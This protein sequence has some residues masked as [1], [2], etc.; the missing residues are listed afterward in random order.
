MAI[1]VKN[2]N[3]AFQRLL[4]DVVKDYRDFA[5]PF[6][7]DIIMSSGGASC[8]RAVQNHVK[9]LWVVL[10]RPREKK[11]AVSADKANMFVESWN[12]PLAADEK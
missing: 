3:A 8:E 10:Q 7:N 1:G 5:R 9:H 11:L 6:V 4:D 12:R 2:G